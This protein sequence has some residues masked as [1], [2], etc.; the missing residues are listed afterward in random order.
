MIRIYNKNGVVLNTKDKYCTE[1]IEIAVDP[2]NL[3]PENIVAGKVILG[4]TGT[5]EGGGGSGAIYDDSIIVNGEPCVVDITKPY[6][7]DA[8]VIANPYKDKPE[9]FRVTIKPHLGAVNTQ[10]ENT[11]GTH[12]Y[13]NRFYFDVLPEAVGSSCKVTIRYNIGTNSG[14]PFAAI[15]KLDTITETGSETADYIIT[16]KEHFE[17]DY[18]R[19]CSYTFTDLTEGRH[20]VDTQVISYA[21]PYLTVNVNW[22]LVD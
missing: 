2:T 22:E 8:I 4:V 13:H 19:T 15:G 11:F 17:E 21:G 16:K 7:T 12:Y 10:K 1:N 20:F 5:G 18:T 9:K 6:F 3:V 14:A